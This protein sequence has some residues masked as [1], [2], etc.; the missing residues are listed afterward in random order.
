MYVQQASYRYWPKR[1]GR[2]E[3]YG[4]CIVTHQSFEVHGD[5]IIRKLE[6]SKHYT[7]GAT[8]TAESLKVTLFHFTQWKEKE[9]LRNNS[10]LLSL[11]EDVNRVQMNT[12]NKPIMVMCK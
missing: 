3:E 4:D 11:I 10:S 9:H 5:Y 1:E 12:N 6:V 7:H 2:T 8:V